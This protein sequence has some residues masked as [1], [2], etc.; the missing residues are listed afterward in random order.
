MKWIKG[1]TCEPG[2]VAGADYIVSGDK[3]LLAVDPC[4]GIRIVPPAAFLKQNL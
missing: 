4:R 2:A 1:R 3:D